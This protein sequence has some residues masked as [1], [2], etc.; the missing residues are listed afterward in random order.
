M[1]GIKQLGLLSLVT[2][3][4]ACVGPSGMAPIDDR[5]R[6]GQ[7]AAAATT[8]GQHV[9]K[10]GETLYEI[11]FRYGRDWKELG[12]ANGLREPFIIYPGQQISLSSGAAQATRPAM[13]SRPAPARAQTTP[14]PARSAP[15][16]RSNPQVA[17]QAS[18]P[19]PP[20][21]TVSLP[22]NVA[23]WAWPVQ[24]P[25]LSRFQSNGSL[26]KGI[27]IAGQLGQPV[28]AAASGAVVYAGRGLLGYGEMIIV[29]HDETY[30]SAYAHNSKLLVSEGDQVKVGQ[31][32]AEMG[33]S[34]TDRVKLHFEIRRKG[35]PVD[36]LSYLPKS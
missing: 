1:F 31:V 35:Q 22:A 13:V 5:T 11:A 10:R 9:V 28:K 16:A 33:S 23:G 30:L 21:K 20:A 3:L 17:A 15:S 34:G 4:T 14:V 19:T 12:A 24:G 27:D 26:N 25:L 18:R 8:S 6:G 32:I 36:P 7:R 2:L 29:K